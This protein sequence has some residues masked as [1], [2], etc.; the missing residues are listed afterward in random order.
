MTPSAGAKNLEMFIAAYLRVGSFRLAA[1]DAHGRP[2]EATMI[3]KREIRFAE[4]DNVTMGEL[5]YGILHPEA[6]S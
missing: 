5:E 2:A 3:R 6:T 1:L 4:I